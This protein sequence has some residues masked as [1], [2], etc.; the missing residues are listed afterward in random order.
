MFPMLF[1][2]VHWNT[3]YFT[4][5]LFITDVTSAWKKMFLFVFKVVTPLT[6]LKLQNMIQRCFSNYFSLSHDIQCP[7]CDYELIQ[8]QQQKTTTTKT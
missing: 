8:K 5:L 2:V 4:Y 7:Y 3:I 1:K 6:G